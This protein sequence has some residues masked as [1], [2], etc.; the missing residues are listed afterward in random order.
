M[1]GNLGPPR[2]RPSGIAHHLVPEPV[3]RERGGAETYEPER[4][5]EEGFVHTTIGEATLIE[6]AN[7]YYQGDPRPY[8]VLDVDLDRLAAPVRFDD[9]GPSFP[10]VYG[11]VE[12]AAVARVRRAERDPGGAF[13]GIGGDATG[14]AGA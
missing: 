11:A 4:F 5:A 14:A 6:V 3:W 9:A 7:R 8:L 13:V 10:H 1:S 2:E 12:T